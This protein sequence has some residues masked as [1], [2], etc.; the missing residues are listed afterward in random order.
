MAKIYKVIHIMDNTFEVISYDGHPEA[1]LNRE[2]EFIGSL[3][4]CE[5]FI[6]L[7]EGGYMD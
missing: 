7:H 2:Q 6:R 5:A 3:A 4:D 1:E